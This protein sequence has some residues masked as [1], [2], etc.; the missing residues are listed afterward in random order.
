[1]G[2]KI[3]CSI[4]S[5]RDIPLSL[6]LGTPVVVSQPKSAVARQLRQLSMLY[7]PVESEPARKGWRR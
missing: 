4:P 5:S 7:S 2:M 3:A 1:M 6:N